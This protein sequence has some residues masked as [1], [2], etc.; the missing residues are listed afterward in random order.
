M[1][2]QVSTASRIAGLTSL[3]GGVLGDPALSHWVS[4]IDGLLAEEQVLLADERHEQDLQARS[5][6]RAAVAEADDALDRLLAALAVGIETARDVAQLSGEDSSVWSSVYA[7]LFPDGVHAHIRRRWTEQGP[8]NDAVLRQLDQPEVASLMDAAGLSSLVAALREAQSAFAAGL[9]EAPERSA[10]GA[11]R[12]RQAEA[13]R[14]YSALVATVV[15]TLWDAPAQLASLLAVVVQEDDNAYALARA[16]RR[17]A[18]S[19]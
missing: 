9:A 13:H 1:I 3:R 15:G 8:L 11:L 12:T 16:R 2:R 7:H 18:A 4:R 14:R 19:A 6:A 10:A 5:K 17:K